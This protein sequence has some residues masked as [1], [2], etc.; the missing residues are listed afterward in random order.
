M[1]IFVYFQNEKRFCQSVPSKNQKLWVDAQIATKKA[2]LEAPESR[3]IL[4]WASEYLQDDETLDE[5]LFQRELK[6][7]VDQK[8]P[9]GIELWKREFCDFFVIIGIL[10]TLLHDVYNAWLMPLF[11]QGAFTM[12][13]AIG[14]GWLVRIIGI[15]WIVKMIVNYFV[16]Q[17][18]RSSILFWIWLAIVF[19]AYMAIQYWANQWDSLVWF[20]M[21]LWLMII[22]MILG[23]IVSVRFVLKH[24]M[25]Q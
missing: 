2:M 15:Y 5:D 23:S 14:L 18:N 8:K 22:I 21:P 11:G 4:T 7:K 6:E 1:N 20:T 12:S 9:V 19:F 17:P 25:I 3:V 16:L 24:R 13:L 10:V